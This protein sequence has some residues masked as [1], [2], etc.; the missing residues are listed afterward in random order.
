MLK[1]YMVTTFLE[2]IMDKAVLAIVAIVTAIGLLGVAVVEGDNIIK[3][4]EAFARGCPVGTP[5]GNA[6]KTRCVRP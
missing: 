6:S 1:Y 2:N 3:Q 5:A 4:I